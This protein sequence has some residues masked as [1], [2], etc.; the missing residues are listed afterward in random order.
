M[1]CSP[2]PIS[3][4]SVRAARA[5]PGRSNRRSRHRRDPGV[6]PTTTTTPGPRSTSSTAYQL[7][8]NHNDLTLAQD[9]FNFVVTGWDTSQTD[10]CPGGVFWEDVSGSQ[11][12]TTA[13]AANAEVGLELYQLTKNSADLVMGDTDVPV[14]QHLSR[15]TE[16]SLLRPCQPRWEVNTTIWSYNQGT[17]VGAGVLLYQITGNAELPDCGPE[18]RRSRG[19]LLRD[20]DHAAEPGP[21]LQRHLLSGLVRAE[22]S[23]TQQC[24]RH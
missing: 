19:V 4:R 24:L 17:M 2:M 9:T 16:R 23:P 14:G 21:S 3:M 8:G 18:H 15:V 13:N 22:P 10:G 12:N 20:W 6:T 7:T 11:R 5:N 1:G